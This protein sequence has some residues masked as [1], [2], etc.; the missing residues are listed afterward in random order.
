MIGYAKFTISIVRFV[1]VQLVKIF[2]SRFQL[3][4]ED[5]SR[6]FK[7]SFPSSKL[8]FWKF[9]IIIFSLHCHQTIGYFSFVHSTFNIFPKRTHCLNVHLFNT[10]HI[11]VP[12]PRWYSRR[13]HRSLNQ[14]TLL[15]LGLGSF[16]NFSKTLFRPENFSSIQDV[17]LLF[18]QQFLHFS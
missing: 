6:S 15:V 9:K 1:F 12:D 5:L 13:C 10:Y 18:L 4:G 14:Q 7:Q 8:H 16:W 11:T 3:F 2:E 17:K